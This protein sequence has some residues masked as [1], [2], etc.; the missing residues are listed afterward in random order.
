MT[1]GMW[2]AFGSPSKSS[3]PSLREPASQA[4]HLFAIPNLPSS[5]SKPL[6][7]TPFSIRNNPLFSTPRKLDVDLASSGGETPKSPERDNN[8]SDATPENMRLRSAASKFDQATMPTFTAG[9]TATTAAQPA[10][11][12]RRRDS[13]WS[14]A[15]GLVSSPGRGEVP[16]GVYSDKVVKRVKK[17]RSREAAAHRQMARLRQNSFSDSES[18]EEESNNRYNNN[19]NNDRRVGSRKTSGGNRRGQHDNTTTTG[20]AAAA[21]EHKGPHFL[22]TF[23]D[24]LDAHPSLPHILSWYAQLTLNIFLFSAF[25]YILYSFWSTIRSDVDKKSSELLAEMA[26]CAQQYTENKCARDT[27]VP[28]MEVVCN[29]WEKCMNRDTTT[30][31]RARVSAHTFAEIFNSFLE[32][33]SY[34]AMVQFSP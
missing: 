32:P 5:P 30:V 22:Y 1:T 4:Q 11:K 29:N 14:K 10:K 27:R 26:V 25:S 13:W 23:F 2:T 33:I 28:A 24:F 18:T 15:A 21:T 17:K 31:G 20:A 7:P 3:V 34:K 16:R 12:D 19:N 6:P 8:D 9:S